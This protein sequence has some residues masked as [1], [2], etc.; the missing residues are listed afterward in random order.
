MKI[1]GHMTHVPLSGGFW[2]II[3]ENGQRFRP[4]NALAA[5]FCIDGLEVVAEVEPVQVFSIFMWGKDVNVTLIQTVQHS[6]K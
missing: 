3:D 5:E 4:V 1:K 2:G 6:K